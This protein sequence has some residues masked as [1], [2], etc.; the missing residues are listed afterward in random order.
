MV[1]LGAQFANILGLDPPPFGFG[2]LLREVPVLA[3]VALLLVRA[4]AAAPARVRAALVFVFVSSVAA[5]QDVVEGRG[6]LDVYGGLDCVFGGVAYGAVWFVA[7][8]V[9]LVVFFVFVAVGAGQSCSRANAVGL[10]SP[11]EVA[12]VRA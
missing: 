10:Q 5:A 8:F 6:R 3:A 4:Q 1:V 12:G 2:L 11:R 7:M 9:M